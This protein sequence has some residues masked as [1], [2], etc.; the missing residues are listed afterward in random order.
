MGLCHA[1]V[2]YDDDDDDV[3]QKQGLSCRSVMFTLFSG[4]VDTEE[5]LGSVC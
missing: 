5:D 3:Q 2:G 1:C 4:R